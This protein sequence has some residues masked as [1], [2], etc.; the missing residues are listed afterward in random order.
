MNR[1][2][3]IKDGAIAIKNGSIVFVGNRV[4]ADG[5]RAEELI[6]AHGKVAI[7]GLINCHT[8]VPMTLFRGVAEDKPL[9]VWLKEAIW[10]LEAKL[11]R[12]DIYAGAMLG[13][14]EMIKSGTTCFADMYFREDVVAEAVKRCG[15]R[16]VLAEGIIEAGDYVT[17]EKMLKNSI[18]FAEKFNGYAD[19]R[20][21]TMLGPHAAYSCS[22]TLLERI[23]N[24]AVDHGLG[25]HIHLA[26]SIE[27]FREFEKKYGCS[28]TQFLDKLGFFDVHVLAA[29]CIDISEEDRRVLAGR[30]VNVA[31]VPVANM[32]LGLQSARIKELA[33][34]NVNVCFGT[35]GPAS[36]NTLDMFETMKVGTL[37]QKHVY[38]DPAVLP[39]YQAL[40][41]ATINGAIALGLENELG[42]IEVGKRADIILIDLSKPHL[43]PLHDIYACLVY[44]AR[45]SDVDT[46]IVDGQILMKN[47]EVKTI[48]EKEVM[49][50]AEE[51]AVALLSRKN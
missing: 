12:E 4:S 33:D 28:E 8:H 25:V 9:K 44:A 20:V 2:A 31:Y 38:R 1:K 15:L 13:C 6:D 10:P 35:D 21:K 29:H 3:V 7:P 24:E 43:K 39:A 27:L 30:H 48:D 11:T 19:N 51:H 18:D 5:F 45:G 32:K 17:G 16:A 41:M 37:L 50:K 22:P 23:R 14:L 46:V 36:N 34:L 49:K 47:R 40:R 42:S 26:E